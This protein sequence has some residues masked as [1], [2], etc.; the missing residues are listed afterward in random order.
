MTMKDHDNNIIVIITIRPTIIVIVSYFLLLSII[1]LKFRG[2]LNT[3]GQKY[4]NN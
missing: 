2:I 1:F 3:S 4:Y